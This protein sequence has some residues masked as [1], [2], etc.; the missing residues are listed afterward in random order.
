MKKLICL[1]LAAVLALSLAACGGAPAPETTAPTETTGETAPE[2]NAA[3]TTHTVVD[4]LDN[5]VEVPYEVNRIVVCDIY[6]LP[7]ALTVFFD[8]AEKIVGMPAPSMTAAANGLLGQLYPQI[9]DAQTGF[10]DGSTINMEEL[11]KLQPDVVF[12]S[13]SQPQEGEQLRNAGIPALAVS[14]N[15][16]QYNAIETLNNW[17]DLLSQVFPENDK[18]Q[19][20]REYSDK[21]YDLVQ[22]R[23]STLEEADRQRVF[24]L[25]QYTDTNMLTS[26]KQ[27]FGQWWADAIGAVNVAQELEKD[28]SVAVNME[29][30]YAWNPSLIFVTNFTKFGPEDLYNNTVGTYDWSAVDAVK[31]HQVYKMPL[32]MYRSYT[33]G[34]DTP[35]TLLW[36]AKSAYPQLFND[37]DLI[38]ETKAYYQE[39]FGIALTDEQASAIFAPPA[40]AGTGF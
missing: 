20:V 2:T 15:K 37:I 34:V 4:H 29:Q 3:P 11:L 30:V 25:F 40:E 12:Y 14:V 31:N 39:V 6:P 33:P 38:A 9:L 8:S 5:A 35:V 21:M 16:W 22:Q 24:F 26:G 27:F 36:L 13:A 23:V 19:V 28:N 7:S 32:G 17:I 1:L 10:I 18:T